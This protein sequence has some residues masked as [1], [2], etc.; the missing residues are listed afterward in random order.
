[1]FHKLASSGRSSSASLYSSSSSLRDLRFGCQGCLGAE[2]RVESGERAK[3]VLEA[4]RLDNGRRGEFERD[5]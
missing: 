4:D 2:F 3:L 1:M 5:R